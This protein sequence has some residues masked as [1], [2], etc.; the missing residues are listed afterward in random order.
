MQVKTGGAAVVKP[1]VLLLPLVAPFLHL[2]PQHMLG[3]GVLLLGIVRARRVKIVENG[4]RNGMVQAL[5]RRLAKIP[6][7]N[8]LPDMPHEA[9][10]RSHQPAPCFISALPA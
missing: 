2:R 10:R 7:H 8:P 3:I 1:F 5:R 6:A 9:H 4:G